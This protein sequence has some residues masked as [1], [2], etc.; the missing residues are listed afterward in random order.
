MIM[1]H[2]FFLSSLFLLLFIGEHSLL[3]G[4]AW[5]AGPVSPSDVLA[6]ARSSEESGQMTQARTILTEGM[7]LYPQDLEIPRAFAQLLDRYG[8]PGRKQAYEQW[9]NL[10]PAGGYSEQPD[11]HATVTRRLVELELLEGN[12]Q[13]AREYLSLHREGGGQD[14][15]D[16]EMALEQAKPPPLPATTVIPGPLRSFLR[17][18][19]ISQK[20][21]AEDVLAFLAR[22]VMVEGYHFWSGKKSG[23]PTEYLKLLM[24]YTE[25]ARELRELAGLD[26]VLRVAGCSD[27]QPLLATLGYRFRDSCGPDSVLQTGD[28]EKAF[29]TVDSG[30][31]LVDL[32]EALRTGTPFAHPFTGSQVPTLFSPNDWVVGEE[33]VIDSLMQ[34][35]QL[36][37][38]YWALARLDEETRTALWQDPGMQ[39]LLPLAS[40]LDFYGSH[41]T[42]R[43]GRVLVPGGARS[44]SAWKDLVGADPDS[45]GEF[46]TRLLEKDEGWLAVYFDALSRINRAQQALFTEPRRM[47]R[48]YE[49]LRGETNKDLP[50]PARPVFRPNAGL[51]LLASRLYLGPDG[52]PHVPGNLSVWKE[53]FR[54]KSDS[55]LV[56]DLAKSA[57]GWDRPEELLE[58][59]MTLS[60]D[61]GKHGPLQIYLALIEIDRHRT[62]A[63]RLN[64]QTVRLMAEKFSRLRNQYL[65]FSEWGSLDND[66]INRFLNAADSIDH[67]R[68]HQVRADA[69]GLFQASVG[70]WQILARQG[71]ILEGMLNNSF[72]QV[73]HPFSGP[74]SPVEIFDAAQAS[75]QAILQFI[76]GEPDLSQFE[77]VALLAAPPQTDPEGQQMRQELAEKI[78]GVMDAQRLVPLDTLLELSAGMKD[79]ERGQAASESLIRLAG[80]LRE[81]EMPL[82]IFS[83]RERSEWASGLI[84]NPHTSLQAR[85]DLTREINRSANSPQKLADVR[86]L[87]TPFLRDTLVGLN[88]A[89]YEP[90]GAQILH[91]NSLFVRSHDFSGRMTTTG[92]EAWQTPRMFGRGWTAS[93]GAYLAG[94]L[95]SLPY[96]LAQ[97][98]QDF[99]VPENIQSL[100]WSDLAPTILAS[101]TLPRW[102]QVTRNEM[103]AVALYQRLGEDLL[104]AA[105]GEEQMQRQVSDILFDRLLPQRLKQVE[106]ALATARLDEAVS[107]VMPAELAFLAA[108]FRRRFPGQAAQWSVAAKELETLW[109]Q[110]PD[111]VS[112]ERISRDFGVP[113]PALANTYARELLPVKPFPTFLGYSSRLMAE[114]WDS[115]NL[116]WARLADEAGY[117]PV[118]LHSIIP[119]LTRRMIEKIFA[120][121]LEDW[122]AVLRALRETGEEFRSGKVSS[123]PK[124]PFADEG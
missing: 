120:T 10:L 41:I 6:Q 71:Q 44:E 117:A 3:P 81:F 26:G 9:L 47:R 96:V 107:Q 59:M 94:S 88:Y 100:I 34:N 82:P 75:L 87:L 112:W 99:L 101:A 28:P 86:G 70:L 16:L 116:Y 67:I 13:K 33:D 115:H 122:S 31:P 37:R 48:L 123:L 69:M 113:H 103:H 111:E 64:P 84:N 20:A 42:I 108:E 124:L 85:T 63:Q 2:A 66:S 4:G 50:N 65:L 55:R 29:L 72:Q 104:T 91:N 49:A 53:I 105:V 95:A 73:V 17:M 36:A 56:R 89:Y 62:P 40:V 45:P 58:A 5:A 30:F 35:P 38:L 51:L 76:K 109:Q 74:G 90:P 92:E 97:V 15:P 46:V 21:P 12:R 7:K 22:N 54:R 98:E 19:A 102:W 60:R 68:D 32:E 121:H 14:L 11:D 114:S 106:Q 78:H 61:P 8:Q 80:Q 83:R 52:E 39:T 93:G 110:Y 43:S 118:M 27:V 119:E 57:S 23:K 18:A 79:M 1:K 25:Q 24:N 77:I